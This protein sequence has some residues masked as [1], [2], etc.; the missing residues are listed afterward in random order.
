MKDSA[1]DATI[2]SAVKVTNQ[3]VMKVFI[4]MMLQASCQTVGE[5]NQHVIGNEI[6]QYRKTVSIHV[7]CGNSCHTGRHGI[8]CMLVCGMTTNITLF[9]LCSPLSYRANGV[10]RA[11]LKGIRER[12]SNE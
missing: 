4:S 5:R 1:I 3:K 6:G 8:A 9:A 2:Q 7:N 12:V 10:N 11:I